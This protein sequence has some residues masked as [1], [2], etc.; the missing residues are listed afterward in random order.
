MQLHCGGGN[1]KKQLKKAD[2][3]E[4]SIALILGDDEVEKNEIVIKYLREKAEQI[5]IPQS[6]LAAQLQ[7]ILKNRI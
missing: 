1:F 7:S 3:S 4:A 5:T 6:E 2:K